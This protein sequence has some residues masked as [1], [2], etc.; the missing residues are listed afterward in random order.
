MEMKLRRTK[1]QVEKLLAKFY[2]KF[3]RQILV[4]N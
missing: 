2:Q 1:K 3:N 4:K